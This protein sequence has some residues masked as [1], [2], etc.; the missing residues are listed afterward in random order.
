[1][2]HARDGTQD[3]SVLGQVLHHYTR[4]PLRHILETEKGTGPR[5]AYNHMTEFRSGAMEAGSH[6]GAGGCEISTTP[7]NS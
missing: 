6:E 7:S 3:L 1:M 5:P 4:N 2:P